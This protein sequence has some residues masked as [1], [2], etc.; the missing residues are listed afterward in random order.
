[1]HQAPRF[2]CFHNELFGH[3]ARKSAFDND[4]F[5]RARVCDPVCIVKVRTGSCAIVGNSRLVFG[6][7]DGFCVGRFVEAQHPALIAGKERFHKTHVVGIETP[8]S[9]HFDFLNVV[10]LYRLIKASSTS[11]SSIGISLDC[12][13]HLSRCLANIVLTT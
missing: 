7:P 5:G 9:F 3:S 1:M 12:G 10:K 8:R 11:T 13:Q 6:K 4:V 2:H